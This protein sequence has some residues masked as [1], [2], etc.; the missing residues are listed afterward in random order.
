MIKVPTN[1]F[2]IVGGVEMLET[3]HFSEPALCEGSALLLLLAV[4]LSPILRGVRYSFSTAGSS[5]GSLARLSVQTT[6][7]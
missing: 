3:L 4:L 5:A 6:V 2:Y 7:L 1:H